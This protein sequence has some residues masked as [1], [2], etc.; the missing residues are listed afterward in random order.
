MPGPARAGRA[1]GRA[2][3]RRPG[4]RPGPRHRPARRRRAEGPRAVA[5]PLADD[6][7]FLRRVYL[8]LAGRIP[9]VSEVRAFLDD[10]R[11]DKRRRLVEQAPRQ[12]PT[13]STTS[14]TSGAT[15][16]CRQTTTSRCSSSPTQIEGWVRGHVQDNVALRPDGPRAAHHAD[17]VG[18]QGARPAVSPRRQ[19]AAPLAFF[20]ANEFKPEN[21]AAATSRLFLGVKLEC[22]QCHDHPF[23]KWKR[24]QFWELRRLLRRHQAAAP[25]AT[26][27]RRPTDDPNG[28]EIDHPRHRAR[29]SQAKFL[30]GNEP[31]WKDERRRPRRR[32]PTG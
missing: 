5:A 27:S 4:D 11:P 30:D 8:D 3:R 14:P 9:R 7:E 21:L 15:C 32:W 12:R 26:S 6:D 22:A 13:T 23:A 24:E 17:R 20:Q 31:K 2:R 16:C 19:T 10:K 29:W 28:R 18:G 1:G 25:A